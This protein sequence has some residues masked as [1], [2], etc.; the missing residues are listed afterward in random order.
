LGVYYGLPWVRWPRSAHEPDQAVLVD[1]QGERFYFFFIEIWPDELYFVTGL[2][3]LSAIALFLV[4][5]VYGRLWCGFACPQTVWTDL[6]IAVERFVEGDRNKRLKLDRQAWS[7]EKMRKKAVKHFLWLL[8]AAATG[9]AWVLYF[10]DAPTVMASLFLGKAPASAYL[11]IGILTFTTYALA[12]LMREQ[13]CTYMCPWPRIQAAM[14]DDQTFTVGYYSARG[15]P[16]GKHKKGQSWEGRGDCIDCNGCVVVCPMGIDIRDGDQ[17]ECINCGLCIDACDDVMKKV[18]RPKGLIAYG[19]DYRDTALK[20]PRRRFPEL[21]RVRTLFY[22]SALVVVSALLVA[23]F[24]TNQKIE[25]SA[26][27]N[28]APAFTR[29]SDGSIRNA[30]TL[31]LLNKNSAVQRFQI[32]VTGPDALE[33]QVVGQFV[34]ERV[35]GLDVIGDKQVQLRMFL[36][37][38]PHLAI[39]G[40]PITLTAKNLDTGEQVERQLAFM[41][42]GS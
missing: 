2:L 32:V 13:V 12:G 20:A 5:S 35:L 38:P 10:H 24:L 8:I 3:V 26:E 37:L 25:F 22:A 7:F 6:F 1:F 41:T 33:V 17:L 30:V 29:L 40:V 18:G 28:R 36:T 39:Q 31:R 19:M 11:F 16:R 23:G 9:G 14:T 4:T 15:E 27:R 21:I 34:D 42:G